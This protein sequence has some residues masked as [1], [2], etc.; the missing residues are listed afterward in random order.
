MNVIASRGQLRA[1]FMRWALFTV[2]LVVLLG[3][4]AGKLGSPQTI[5]FQG[6]VKPAIYPPPATFGLVWTVLYAMIG[7]SL[8]L[9]CSAWGARGRRLAIMLF[10]IH[11]PINLAF[12]PVFFGNQNIMG[13]LIVMGLVDVTLIAMV[14]TFWRVRRSAGL[15]LLPYLA[16]AAFASVLAWQFHLL[17]PEGGLGGETVETQRIVL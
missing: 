1:S 17:N 7:L 4:L 11:L 15:L 6:L 10:V 9:V 14:L 12:T 16:W 13:G 3:F 2:P 8:A 5:W